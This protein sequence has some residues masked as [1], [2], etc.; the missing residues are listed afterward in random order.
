MTLQYW[1]EEDYEQVEN[2]TTY[3]E[4]RDVAFRVLA[5]APKPCAEVCGPITTGGLGSI[6]K[7]LKRFNEEIRKLQKTGVEVFDQM[8]FEES[9][10]RIKK[11]HETKGYL[12]NL[13]YEFYLPIFESGLIRTLYFLPDW[14]TS[15]GARWEHEQAL[16][17][18]IEI[19]YL[20]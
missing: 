15:S 18:G 4:L 3:N 5:R 19:V 20:E 6:E 1:R 14:K 9:M 17:L 10:Q 11:L 7:N 16:R 12:T 13:L 8:P 2:A